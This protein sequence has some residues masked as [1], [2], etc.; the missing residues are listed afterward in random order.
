MSARPRRDL[1]PRLP[2]LRGRA[3]EPLAPAA[4]DLARRHPHLARARPRHRR[5]DRAVAADRARARRRWSCSSCSPRSSARRRPTPNDFELPVVR[6]VLRVRDRPARPL[7]GRRRAA[8]ALPRPPRRRALALRRA[9][10]HADRLRRR[11]LGGVLHRRRSPRLAARGGPLRLEPARRERHRLVAR[12]QLGHRAALPRRRALVLAVVLTTLALLVV[13]VHDA[14]RVRGDRD[15]RRALH[16]RRAR[17]HRARTTSPATLADVLSL[18]D[19]TQADD[20]RRA[21]DLRRR[22][23]QPGVGAGRGALPRRRSTIVLA[24]WL[25]AAPSGWCADDR[26]QPVDR[27]RR[28]LALVRRRRRGERRDA[29]GRARA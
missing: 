23:R 8:A 13:V 15:A 3:H 28:P 7:R 17:R 9:A 18:A 1:R 21:L 24:V 14:A 25:S 26:A 2:R 12:R 20:R 11:A 4:R 16:R 6:R 29:R 22:A 10:D 19:L 27:D 5:E